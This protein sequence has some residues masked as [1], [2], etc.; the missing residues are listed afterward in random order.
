MTRFWVTGLLFLFSTVLTSAAFE[1]DLSLKQEELIFQPAAGVLV[2]DAVRI[3]TKVWNHSTLD[4]TGVVKFFVNGTQI[5]TDQPISVQSGGVPDEV[6]I[7]WQ[8]E[9]RGN[10]TIKAE[11]FPNK[12]EGDDPKNNSVRKNLFVDIDTDRDGVG[13]RVDI[14]DDNDGLNDEDERK[15]NTN[16]LKQDTDGDGSPNCNDLRDKF[17]LNAK[18]CSDTDNDGIGNNADPDDDNDGLLDVREGEIKTDPLNPDTDGDGLPNCNDLRDKFPL[19]EKECLDDDGDGV[20][21]NSD[22]FPNDPRETL[23]CDQDG[24]GNNADPDDDND[25]T[26]DAQ[27][28][29]PCNP[30]E[31]QDCD[32]DGIGDNADPDDDNDGALD[33]EDAFVCDPVEAKDNDGDGLGDNADPNDNNLGPRPVAGGDRTV[34]LGEVVAFDASLSSDA[35]GEVVHFVWNFGDSSPK[36]EEAVTEHIFKRTGEFVTRLTVTD[37]AGESRVQEILVVVENLPWLKNTIF[38]LMW[39]LLLLL[40]Y[41]FWQTVRKKRRK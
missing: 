21:N 41:I 19:N 38:W 8:A 12:K 39:I 7:I 22:A 11:L 4:L 35:D 3:Y 14:D 16:P 28:A 15:K 24:I 27:D 33:E 6:F 26:K 40:I 20:G 31:T 2:G 18:E 5:A 36:V 13:N 9:A 29:L 10:Y 32:Q 23:D 25:G 30:D 1:N 17:P 37:N 34:I